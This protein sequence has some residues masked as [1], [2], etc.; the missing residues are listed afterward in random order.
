MSQLLEK[1]MKIRWDKKR[2][3]NFP[4]FLTGVKRIN[5]LFIKASSFEPT[6]RKE[7]KIPTK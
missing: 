5:E 2:P 7:D 4:Y 6:P 3:I 1:K